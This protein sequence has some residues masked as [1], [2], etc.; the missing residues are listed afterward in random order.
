MRFHCSI[1][2]DLFEWVPIHYLSSN[3]FIGS[4]FCGFLGIG[5]L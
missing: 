5:I 3:K 2:V 1:G 4:V